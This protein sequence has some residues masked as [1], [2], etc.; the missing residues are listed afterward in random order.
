MAKTIKFNLIIDK[1]PIRDLEDLQ[2]HFNIEDLLV[3][4]HNGSLKRWLE[5]RELTAELEKVAKVEKDAGD[6]KKTAGDLCKIFQKDCTKEQ[7]ASAVYPFEFRKR[8]EEKLRS[9]GD[10]AKEKTRLIGDY[11]SEYDNL[12]KQMEEKSDDYP[13]IKASVQQIF[14]SYLGLYK[15]DAKTFYDRFLEKGKLVILSM[16]ANENMRLLLP[17]NLK[18]VYEDVGENAWALVDDKIY[19]TAAY[20]EKWKTDKNQ[21]EAKNCGWPEELGALLKKDI[22]ILSSSDE[23]IVGKVIN[24]KHP[25][26]SF[27]P[28]VYVD[29][30][31]F[32]VLPSERL[33][34]VKCF[35]GVT[36]GYWK[37]IEPK[38]KKCLIIKMKDTNLVR[39]AAQNGEELKADDVNGKF[40]TLNGIDYK[41]NN[42]SHKLIYMEI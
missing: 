4:F 10:L 7:I 2:N 23:N 32:H 8:E 16:L 39:S 36:E 24:S 29:C 31:N 20:I 34:P 19:D 40:I 5:A 25:M 17:Y 11:H 18:K 15:L 6:D 3:A 41:S 30:A 9:Y 12:L 38:N 22:L 37:D 28:F 35:S 21:P 42:A 26:R 27:T 33:S 13:F 14:K 1:Q